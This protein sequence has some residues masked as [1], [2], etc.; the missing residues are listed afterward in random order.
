MEPIESLN[1][2]LSDRFG[3]FN[4]H[5]KFRVVWS[6]DQMEKRFG[7]FRDIT[8]EGFFLREVTETREVPKYR[9]YIHNK[10]ILERYTEV[11]SFQADEIAGLKM[12]YECIWVFEDGQGKAL[13]VIWEAC[14]FLIRNLLEKMGSRPTIYKDESLT[15]EGMEKEFNG[16]MQ[17]LYGDTSAVADALHYKEG[18][19]VPKNYK[20][21]N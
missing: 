18:I 19:V 11:P 5:P 7:T 14:E 12:S 16:I 1:S 13:P 21:N 3:K 10:W 9:Q 2:R 17:A 4:D 20:E 6:E 8:S 15:P